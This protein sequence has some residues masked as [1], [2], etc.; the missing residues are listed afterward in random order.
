[1]Q[2]YV[3]ARKKIPHF[4]YAKTT[5]RCIFT[6]ESKW[7]VTEQELIQAGLRQDP[8]AQQALYELYAPVAMG[9][10]RRY[11]KSEDAAED[12]L[13]ET[14]YKVLTRLADY[15]GEGSFEGWVRRIAINEALMYLRKHKALEMNDSLQDFDQPVFNAATET[16]TMAEIL[17]ALDC[18]PAGY[19]AVFN[20]YVIEG[21][22]HREIADILGVSINTS[23]SQLAQAKER[24]QALL[25]QRGFAP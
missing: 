7:R 19:R 4:P 24:M 25:T 5:H 13:I 10:C 3:V 2:S 18:L 23:K 8:K 1:M 14:M 17:Q 6:A 9:V 12:V 11:L 15:K 16:L 20:L 22:K 21:Y